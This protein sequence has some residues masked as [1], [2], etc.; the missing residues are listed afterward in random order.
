MK[1]WMIAVSG[2]VA[3][4][5]MVTAFT[6]E[7]LAWGPRGDKGTGAMGQG[8]GFID[9]NG[10]GV[11]DRYEDGNA[12][13]PV[14]D[15]TGSG[16]GYGFVDEDGDGINDRYEDGNT[17]VPAYDGVG[18]GL[19]YGFIDEDGDGMNDRY[20]DRDG[21][22]I[23]DYDGAGLGYGFVDEDGDG[24][25]DRYTEDGDCVP[26]EDGMAYGATQSGRG[27]RWNR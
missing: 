1:K 14:E 8:I 17:G 26:G 15:G 7:A 4:L 12:G 27:G 23:P 9:E 22:G 10:D 21:D 2:M 25:N 6:G 11:N 16:F 13:T 3:A 18:A 5:L 19:G 20:T 24:V